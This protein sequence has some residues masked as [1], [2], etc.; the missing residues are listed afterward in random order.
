[1]SVLQTRILIVDD[2]E[3]SCRLFAEVLEGDG[4][5]VH[6]AAA[7]KKRSIA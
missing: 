7:V 2:D 6:Q 1:M 4:H 3:V 5:E